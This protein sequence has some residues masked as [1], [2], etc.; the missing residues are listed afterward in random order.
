MQ[1]TTPKRKKT[2]KTQAGF[3]F[4]FSVLFLAAFITTVAELLR[5]L[6]AALE[7]VFLGEGI[8]FV[9]VFLC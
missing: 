5:T 2:N 1:G 9:E 3:Y 8:P 7:V 6:C 4:V